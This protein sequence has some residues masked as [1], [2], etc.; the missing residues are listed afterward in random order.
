MKTGNIAAK[1]LYR[2]VAGTVN[3]LNRLVSQVLL[4]PQGD[5]G[6]E[7]LLTGKLV[8]EEFFTGLACPMLDLVNQVVYRNCL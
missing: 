7:E 4:Q 1:F 5:F 3:I 6:L 8:A 2:R